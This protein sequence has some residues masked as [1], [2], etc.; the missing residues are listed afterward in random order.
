MAAEWYGS[1]G[2]GFQHFRAEGYG[3]GGFRLGLGSL[4]D[5]GLK[6]LVSQVSVFQVWGFTQL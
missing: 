4:E 5:L 2:V 6:F 1:W 3:F